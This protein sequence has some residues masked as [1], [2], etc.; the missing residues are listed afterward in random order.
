MN[1]LTDLKHK[2]V[3]EELSNLCTKFRNFE[4]IINNYS[5]KDKLCNIN[6]KVVQMPS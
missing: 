1:K 6:V 3:S 2:F 5:N 4:N